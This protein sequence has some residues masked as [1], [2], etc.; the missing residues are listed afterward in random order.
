MG[1]EDLVLFRFSNQGSTKWQASFLPI[2]AL[3]TPKIGVNIHTSLTSPE[4]IMATKKPAFLFKGK[5]TGKEEK[6]EKKMSPAMYKKGEKKEEAAMKKAG[7][8][9]TK[10]KY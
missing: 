5:E 4:P 10:G 6:A 8:P 7:K 9:V 1:M 3:D 2:T